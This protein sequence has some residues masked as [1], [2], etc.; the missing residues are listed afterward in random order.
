MSDSQWVLIQGTTWRVGR[1]FEDGVT[2]ADVSSEESITTA[3]QLAAALRD[4]GYSRGDVLLALASTSCLTGVVDLSE[5]P[6]SPDRQTLLYQLESSLPWSAEEVVA[7][8]VSGASH[9]LGIATRTADVLPILEGLEQEGIPI[10]SVCPWSMLAC[11]SYLEQSDTNRASVKGSTLSDDVPSDD[12]IASKSEPAE[13]ATSTSNDPPAESKLPDG[14]STQVTLIGDEATVFLGVTHRKTELVVTMKGKPI[15]WQSGTIDDLQ[16]QLRMVWLSHSGNIRVILCGS[17]TDNDDV[18]AVTAGFRSSCSKLSLDDAAALATREIL[19]GNR[20]PLFELRR[21]VLADSNPF[22]PVAKL[23]M[24]TV[25]SVA[26][27]LAIIAGLMFWKAQQYEQLTKN[28][29]RDQE[30][31]FRQLFPD[32][33]IPIGIRS[34]LQSEKARIVGLKGDNLLESFLNGIPTG[35]RFRVVEILIEG[36]R[37]TIDGEVRTHSDA[38]RLASELKRAGFQVQSP[39]TVQ[40]SGGTVSLRLTAGFREVSSKE[41]ARASADQVPSTDLLRMPDFSTDTPTPDSLRQT[42]SLMAS[43]S[44]LGHS[45]LSNPGVQR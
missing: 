2:Y 38:S 37:I 19:S 29:Q 16:A 44:E 39:R 23:V 10:R 41:Q 5:L 9:A 33:P 45:N 36:S 34:R 35:L 28:Y 24:A 31:V 25:I 42:S 32:Q 30:Q 3:P 4:C 1:L 15:A 17:S 11:Q 20:V 7:D 26:A 14:G 40:L 43:V 8:F 22:R 6:R 27:C 21:G 12:S 13:I 18:R